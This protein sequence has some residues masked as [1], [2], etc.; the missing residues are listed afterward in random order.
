M[1]EHIFNFPDVGEGIH[2]GQLVEWLVKEGDFVK[3]DQVIC[4]VETDKAVVEIPAPVSGKV[5]KL[6]ASPGEVIYVGNPLVTFEVEGGETKAA[7]APP[8]ASNE[9]AITRKLPSHPDNLQSGFSTA[10]RPL[11]P[12]LQADTILSEP[13]AAYTGGGGP[14]GNGGQP[15]GSHATSV[16][17]SNRR[18][19]DVPALPHTRALARKLGVDITRVVGTG[20]AG[21]VTDADVEA[22]YR[23]MKEGRPISAAAPAS[24][25]TAPVHSQVGEL[26]P[27]HREL[28]HPSVQS[29]Q[30]PAA[31]SAP[32]SEEREK[33]VPL[34]FLRKRIAEQMRT[35]V[36]KLA[37]VT[38]FDEADL[39][40]LYKIYKRTKELLAAQEIKLSLMPYFIKAVVA[41]LKEYPIFNST[42]DQ[43][44]GEIVYKYYYNI[45]IAVDTPEGLVV[46]VIKDADR[47]SISQLAVEVADLAKRARERT[48]KLD[49]IRGGTFTITNIGPIG[50]LFATPIINYPE[51]AILATHALRE[52]PAVV[53]GEIQVRKKMYIAVSFDHQIIDGA[54][55]ARFAKKVVTLLSSPDLLFANI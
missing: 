8:A 7:S 45:G 48:L 50:G 3:E 51:S 5:A 53:D 38:H 17:V 16:T 20:P 10:T 46:P 30:A 32:T 4:R 15:H 2:E 1:A 34:S 9:E 13:A 19:Q 47:K 36:T 33:R 40:D 44:R 24:A 6:H 21:R 35:S 22:A 18:P 55:A 49:E 37:H 26:T 27:S 42:F 25:A 28:E 23:A 11:E 52:V 39:T 43:E 29:V 31:P 12:S 41:A 14:G 54:D